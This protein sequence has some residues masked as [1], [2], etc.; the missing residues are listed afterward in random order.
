MT[1]T[2]VGV[3]GFAAL[4]EGKPAEPSVVA[5]AAEAAD[6][7]RS[8]VGV[9]F[10]LGL[11]TIVVANWW[12]LGAMAVFTLGSLLVISFTDIDPTST[13]IINFGLSAITAFVGSGVR[14]IFK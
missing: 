10:S 14:T 8:I 11:F 3:L 9:L 13:L 7:L 12:Q 1:L 5:D 4:I 6:R 2:I